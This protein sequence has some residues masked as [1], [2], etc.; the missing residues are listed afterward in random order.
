MGNVSKTVEK[1]AASLLATIPPVWD[2]IR[3]N[4]RAAGTGKL[5]I[6]L[7]Q[8]HVLRHIRQ[9]YNTVGEIA[10]K[11][12]I[13]KS[14]ASQAVEALASKGLVNRIPDEADRRFVQLELTPYAVK[15]LDENLRET[16]QWITEKMG[17]LSLQELKTVEDAMAILGGTF[18]PLNA[19]S[20]KADK[21]A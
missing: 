11:K 7:E 2:A 10:A 3:V 18:V 17:D 8:F 12:Q 15:I 1:T 20:S 6:S 9:G 4:L 13:S 14:A 21:N 16:R 5:G 19:R